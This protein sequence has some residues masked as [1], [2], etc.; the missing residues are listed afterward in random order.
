MSFIAT[1]NIEYTNINSL[2]TQINP[3]EGSTEGASRHRRK[4]HQP[5]GEDSLPRG[6]KGGG[7]MNVSKI[8][9]PHLVRYI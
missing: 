2:H 5:R 9:F 3:K 1:D 7:T 8:L 6:D 4:R